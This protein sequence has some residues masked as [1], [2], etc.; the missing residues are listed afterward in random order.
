MSRSIDERIVEMRFDNDQFESGVKESMSTLEKLKQS[1]KFEDSAKSFQEI[2]KAANQLDLSQMEGPLQQLADRFSTLGIVGVTA[3]QEL[4]KSALEFASTWVNKVIGPIKDGGLS[5]AMNIEAAKFQL[6]GLGIAWESVADDIDYAVAGTAYG[7]D[8]AA[9]ACSQLSASGVKAGDD[10]KTALRGISGVAAMTGRDYEDIA[11]IFT[12]V[13][14]NGRLMG[15]QLNQLGASGVNAAATLADS[16][17]VTEKELRKFVSEGK[18]S[19]EAFAQSM[20]DAFGEHAKD[21]N[22]TVTGTLSNINA[23]L[24]KI[25]ADFY[26]PVIENE[27]KLVEFLNTIREKIN[28]VRA[29][30]KKFIVDFLAKET[31]NVLTN[32][33][34]KLKSLDLSWISNAL[35][36]LKNVLYKVFEILKPIGQAFNDIFPQKSVQGIKDACDTFNRLIRSFQVSEKTLNNIKNTFRGLFSIIDLLSY[37]FTSILSAVIPTLS[38]L[39]SFADVI[40]EITGTIG[41]FITVANYLIQKNDLIRKSFEALAMIIKGV[42]SA[43]V[44]GIATIVEKVSQLEIVQKTIEALKLGFE[45]IVDV[46]KTVVSALQN[47]SIGEIVDTIKDKVINFISSLNNGNTILT[48]LSNIKTAF[49]DFIGR[50]KE[51]FKALR[52]SESVGELFDK[53]KDKIVST[54]EAIKEFLS[55]IDWS[56]VIVAAYSIAVVAL[57]ASL[58]RLNTALTDTAKSATGFLKALKSVV[59]PSFDFKLKGYT[60]LAL[61]IMLLAGALKLVSTIPTDQ[62]VSCGLAI[63]AFMGSLVVAEA[64][65]A[66][67]NKFIGDLGNVAIQLL[68]LSAATAGLVIALKVLDTVNLDNIW[69]KVLVLT[70]LSLELAAVVVIMGKMQGNVLTAIAS[71]VSLLAFAHT[72]KKVVEALQEFASIP[73]ENITSHIEGFLLLIGGIALIEVAAGNIGVGSFLGL[74]GVIYVMKQVPEALDEMKNINFDGI[75]ACVEKYKLTIIEMGILATVMIAVAGKLGGGVAKFGFGMAL[76]AGSLLIVT[77]V[78]KRLKQLVDAE[79]TFKQAVIALTALMGVI[80][81]MEGISKLTGGNQMIKFSIG[82]LLIVGALALLVEVADMIRE[83]N[84]KL[85]RSEFNRLEEIL[86]GFMACIGALEAI[87]AMTKDAKVGPLITLIGGLAVL[88]TELLMLSMVGDLDSLLIATITMVSLMTMLELLIS[89]ISKMEKPN[90]K[91]LVFVGEMIALLCVVGYRL[92]DLAEIKD[93]NAMFVAGSSLIATLLAVVLG[94]NEI[95]KMKGPALTTVVALGEMIAGI[96]VIAKSLSI[97]AAHPWE[98]IISS[99]MA[100]NI[101]LG[102]LVA[103]LVVLSKITSMGIDYVFIGTAMVELAGSLYIISESLNNFATLGGNGWEAVKEALAIFGGMSIIIGVLAGITAACPVFALAMA[104]VSAILLLAATAFTVFAEG[105]NMVASAYESFINATASLQGIDLPTISSGLSALAGS[106]AL[107]G[108]VGLELMVCAPGLMLG[109]AGI[110]ALG[111]AGTSASLGITALSEVL[112]TFLATDLSG[113]IGSMA[114]LAVSGVEMAA[115]G[116]A[117][118]AGASGFTAMANALS[119]LA[120]NCDAATTSIEN[121]SKNINKTIKSNLE[122]LTK[123]CITAGADAIKGLAQGISS[124]VSVATTAM[125]NAGNSIITALRNAVGWHSPWKILVQAGKDA[126]AGIKEGISDSGLIEGIKGKWNEVCDKGIIQVCKDTG[127]KVKD[128]ASNLVTG[129]QDTFNKLEDGSLFDGIVSGVEEAVKEVT[130]MVDLEEEVNKFTK[131][132]TSLGESTKG[133]GAAAKEAKSYFDELNET[134]E[135]QMD[136]FKEF[137]MESDLTKEQLLANMKSQIDGVAAWTGELYSLSVK[138]LDQGLYKKL[139][140][141][142]PEGYKY[143]HAFTEM[144][145][146][147]LM[148]A[149]KYFADYLIFPSSAASNIIAGYAQAADWASQ[150]FINGVKSDEINAAAKATAEGYLSTLEKGLD[151]HSPSKKTYQIGEYAILGMKNG[152]TD[153][154]E[155]VWERGKS[156]CQILL[157]YMKKELDP[158]YFKEIGE[159]ICKGLEEG[160]RKGQSGVVDA[161]VET[162]K[163]AISEAKSTLDM[164]SPSKVFH[165]IGSFVSE[166]FANGIRDESNLVYNQLDKML[167]G[168]IDTFKNISE[169]YDGFIKDTDTLPDTKLSSVVKRSDISTVNT[170]ATGTIGVSDDVTSNINNI[171]GTVETNHETDLIKF[172]TFKNK[173]YDEFHGLRDDINYLGTTMSRMQMVLDTGTLVGEIAP[174]MDSALGARATFRGR[175]I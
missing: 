139:A 152:M 140:D 71:A 172:E 11:R 28:E 52:E 53:L 46:I 169:V 131:S 153:Y 29:E 158:K 149:N 133:A 31:N 27:G 7:L 6:E 18:I 90:L 42:L 102:S 137:D 142:G 72:I 145:A 88:F 118:E 163:K 154:Q 4:T 62:L 110:I 26:T 19:F 84:S 78:V 126:L 34:A 23:A 156:M 147:E 85:T 120:K 105:Y 73:F 130:N 113:L 57:I 45:K 64:L 55:N 74:L 136:L 96:F 32:L 9:K 170:V 99:M 16:F 122:D 146:E 80:A 83:L 95:S 98:S 12:T 143:V 121:S 132:F 33:T 69:T 58:V 164:H 61:S 22:K 25:G 17:G 48:I 116:V 103:A 168:S 3:I 108:V 60:E 59:Q 56:K 141:M 44:L 30:A 94:L 109:A 106:L 171:L 123:T 39:G 68:A 81:V 129:V 112:T 79:G 36:V 35:M 128:W 49:V 87:S 157:S 20:D 155:Q 135:N 127:Q 114:Q 82:I 115:A 174:G 37:A 97:L 76:L 66:A 5:R 10:M 159:N 167:N 8:A 144:T 161:I 40:L 117:M 24:K 1:L 54:F 125:T 89:E 21:A 151:E 175:G 138:G 160:I 67:I 124:N 91:T 165:T 134:I 43:I 38:P 93:F 15:D 162:C 173:L 50:A 150:G 104:A 13:A 119:S 100:L 41:K 111:A 47:L 14:G 75:L 77:E 92:K 107:L 2:N 86:L 166:G 101:T 70:A 51:F 148:Q 63:V 65:M